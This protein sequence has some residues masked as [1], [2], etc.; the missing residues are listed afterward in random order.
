MKLP[1]CACY[2]FSREIWKFLLIK[3][4]FSRELCINIT[5]PC[6]VK[7][8]GLVLVELLWAEN[9]LSKE[10]E[11]TRDDFLR[12][13]EAEFFRPSIGCF[14]NELID[15]ATFKPWRLS[16]LVFLPVELFVEDVAPPPEVA[17]PDVEAAI[18]AAPVAPWAELLTS[19]LLLEPAEMSLAGPVAEAMEIFS[20][21]NS[22]GP[23]KYWKIA[24]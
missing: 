13:D 3:S 15:D 24:F 10:R 1:H 8:E 11:F 2:Q 17:P 9:R 14:I 23:T 4:F 19:L 18:E 21:S 20:S 7:W 22:A 6:R 12:L 5:L 16:R